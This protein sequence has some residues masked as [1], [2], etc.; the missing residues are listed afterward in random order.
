M[1]SPCLDIGD[2]FLRVLQNSSVVSALTP[3]LKTIDWDPV[4][5]EHPRY[6]TSIKD[7]P[8]FLLCVEDEKDDAEVTNGM[9]FEPEWDGWLYLQQDPAQNATRQALSYARSFQS[10]F[11]AKPRLLQGA[12]AEYF[13][14]TQVIFHRTIQHRL[15]DHPLYRVTPIQFKFE[16]SSTIL[17]S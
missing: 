6:P 11:L 9:K 7:L 3:R 1:L 10:A 15:Q 13:A 12:G 17:Y 16:I 4:R 2:A 5:T 14:V 8:V